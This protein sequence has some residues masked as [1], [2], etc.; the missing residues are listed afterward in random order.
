MWI[1]FLFAEVC[2]FILILQYFCYSHQKTYVLLHLSIWMTSSVCLRHYFH[3]F[4]I[5]F[6]E[7][8]IKNGIRAKLESVLHFP[9]SRSALPKKENDA[10]VLVWSAW[11]WKVD[12]HLP[13][14]HFYSP[15]FE[16]KD[17]I[18]LNSW[19][20]QFLRK[21]TG[22]N[23]AVVENYF[24]L[25]VYSSLAGE[26]VQQVLLCV[27]L[28]INYSTVFNVCHHQAHFVMHSLQTS[29]FVH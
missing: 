19:S 25:L 7:S 27:C 14:S 4:L 21:K 12:H 5:I 6:V 3:Y 11:E 15:L 28:T 24:Q 8:K 2:L 20:L 16:K 13:Y 26:D 29:S 22:V 23:N 10:T 17:T 9:N 18:S 1:F